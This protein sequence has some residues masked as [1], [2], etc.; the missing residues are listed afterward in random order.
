MQGKDSNSRNERECYGLFSPKK[1]AK[2]NK[3]TLENGV[4]ALLYH[5]KQT[6]GFN[7]LK[8]SIVCEWL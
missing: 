5:F 4:T 6:G 8:E 3:Y 7:N 1:K 2:V